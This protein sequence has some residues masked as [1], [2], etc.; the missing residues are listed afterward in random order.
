MYQHILLAAALQGWDKP[1]SHAL[2]ARDAAVALAKGAGT[3]LSMLSVYEYEDRDVPDLAA[4]WALNRIE[5]IGNTW[6]H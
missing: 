6:R 3:R 5:G 1:S 2:A 4:G